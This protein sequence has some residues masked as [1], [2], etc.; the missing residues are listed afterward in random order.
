[1]QIIIGGALGRMGRELAKAAGEAG[2]AVACGVDV[3][4]TAQASDFPMVAEYHQITAQADALVDFSRADGLAELLAYAS[5]ARMPLV[6]CTTG[7]TETE[8]AAIIEATRVIPILRSANMSLGV[9]VLQKLAAMAARALGAGFDVEIVEKHHR[10]KLDSPS[11]TAL[12][13]YQAVDRERNGESTVVNGRNSRSQ[14]RAAGEIG[15]HAV[16]GGTVTG[17]HE[18]GFYGNAE[19]IILTHRAENRGLFAEG[20]LR[21]AMFLAG[22][23]AGLYSMQDV[24]A[25]MVN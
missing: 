7:Y 10:Q 15:I 17:E 21:A 19:E 20:A 12:M 11:G 25:E 22:K 9:N 23:P 1:M 18:V 3:A 13:L 4:Y 14:K 8:V 5:A 16:R 6:L 2:V 24:V